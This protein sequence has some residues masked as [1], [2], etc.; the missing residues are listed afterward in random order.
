[1]EIKRWRP[2]TA[3]SKREERLMQRLTRTRKLFGFLRTHRAE[4]F[5]DGFQAEL[6]SMYR[7][8]GAGKLPVAP[9]LVAMALLLQAYTGV[10][11]ADAVELTVVDARWQM[12]LDWLGREKPAFSQGTLCEF[13]NRL[14][15]HEM[16]RRLLERTVELARQ[17]K[18]FD[19]RKLPKTLR[20]GMDS[21]PLEGAGRVEDTINL[22][23]H[24]AR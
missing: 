13:R 16:D 8:S 19:W 2:S 17:S 7:D 20:V 24:A 14:I 6:E 10:S 23:A 9:A 1:M 15:A 4:L 21:S 3:F 5:D 11:D 18:I 22:L 12:V